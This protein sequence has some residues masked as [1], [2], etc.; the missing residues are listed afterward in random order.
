MSYFVEN[1]LHVFW[2][3]VKFAAHNLKVSLHLNVILFI[4]NKVSGTS[5]KYI[6]DLSFSS[7]TFQYLHNISAL[8]SEVSKFEQHIKLCSKCSILI[9][10]SLNLS[11]V[12]W[13]KDSSCSWTLLLSW[14]SEFTLTC[15]TFVICYHA[16]QTAEI[17]HILLMFLI[18]RNLY[19]G[20]LP[21]DSHYLSFFPK[22]IVEGDYP[23]N[24]ITW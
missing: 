5:Y 19:W 24:V 6:Y 8:L 12:F 2:Y 21:W 23:G 22:F 4:A 9:V 3:Q 11:P 10:S 15:T 20:W 7:T 13:L 17:S 16:I 18:Y 1:W 14:Q